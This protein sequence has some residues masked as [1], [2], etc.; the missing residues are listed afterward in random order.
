MNK[1]I[2]NTQKK[3][4]LGYKIGMTTHPKRSNHK[5]ILLRINVLTPNYFFLFFYCCK[6][7]FFHFYREIKTQKKLQKQWQQQA[8]L[9]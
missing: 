9:E 5:D 8:N 4:E 1:G 2:R 7:F 6:H 3:S